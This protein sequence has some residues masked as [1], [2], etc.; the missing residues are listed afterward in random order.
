MF[1][2][3]RHLPLFKVIAIVQ[4]ALLARRHLGVL[5][6]DER[7]RAARLVRNAR[8]LTPAE[9]HELIDIA[10]Q[11]GAARVRRRGGR[12]SV[13]GAAAAPGYRTRIEAEDAFALPL[14]AT[15]SL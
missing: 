15:D 12:P 6:P 13:A 3:V 10:A 5:T 2:T 4:L 7:R 1:R 8:K 9:R 14:S 11:A